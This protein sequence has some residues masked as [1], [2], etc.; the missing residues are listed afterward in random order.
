MSRYFAASSAV[1]GGASALAQDEDEDDFMS[2]K[3]LAAAS[4]EDSK[5]QKTYS[6]MRKE[7][8][9]KAEDN[10]R[11]KSRAEREKEAREEGLKRSL[12]FDHNATAA[13]GPSSRS[14]SSTPAL[15]GDK[16]SSTSAQTGSKGSSKALDMML[17]MGF[18]PGEAL[19]KRARAPGIDASG[20]NGHTGAA[21]HNNTLDDSGSEDSDDDGFIPL[22]AGLGSRKGKAASRATQQAADAPKA[23][24]DDRRVDP[25]EIQMRAGECTPS[26]WCPD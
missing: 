4:N 11:I 16:G 18:K 25:I 21:G 8:V 6:Q 14:G 2:D 13:A 23:K 17:K 15:E 1:G 9:R 3:F 26:M 19:G 20:S 24:L 22:N 12:I 5:R 7:A 10:G